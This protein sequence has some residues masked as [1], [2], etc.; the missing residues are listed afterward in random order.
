MDHP[1]I[2]F[3]REDEECRALFVVSALYHCT[4]VL[5]N[6]PIRFVEVDD[7]AVEIAVEVL[8]FDTGLLVDV[9]PRGVP[10][11][12][13]GYAGGALFAAVV[14]EDVTRIPVYLA[15]RHNV[16]QLVLAQFPALHRMTGTVLEHLSAAQNPRAF[17]RVLCERLG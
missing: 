17:A 11:Q 14:L 4:E 10:G 8:R 16:P 13:A 9:V 3:G 5:S 2:V 1:L 6:R 7:V 15:E 12:G